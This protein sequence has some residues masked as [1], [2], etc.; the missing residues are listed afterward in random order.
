MYTYITCQI[1]KQKQIQPIVVYICFISADH[2][3]KN[4]WLKA[5][6]SVNSYMMH[7]HS[8]QLQPALDQLLEHLTSILKYAF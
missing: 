1:E 8:V 6:Y 7:I 4:I 3:C 5:I 2:T